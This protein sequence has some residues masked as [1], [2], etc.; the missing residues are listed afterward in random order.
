MG[1]F[2]YVYC[3]QIQKVLKKVLA[4]LSLSLV[5]GFL[6]VSS[7]SRKHNKFE[8]TTKNVRP[9]KKVRPSHL[10]NFVA[11]LLKHYIGK[12]IHSKKLGAMPSR[13]SYYDILHG[14][15]TPNEGINQRNLKI[16]ADVA[17]K[18]CFGRT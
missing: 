7:W 8:R 5:A 18:I 6:V 3:I 17:D 15:R 4:P 1:G 14:L 10:F 2:Q 9:S 16:W 13:A 11:S 12:V